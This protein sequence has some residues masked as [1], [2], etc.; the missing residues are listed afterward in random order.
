MRDELRLKLKGLLPEKFIIDSAI[1]Y[2]E[3]GA[4]KVR[5]KIGQWAVLI[6]W[7]YLE[8]EEMCWLETVGLDSQGNKGEC[9]VDNLYRVLSG[10]S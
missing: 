8:N 1:D 4:C 6:E 2:P 9:L 10:L 5:G 3:D 7:H